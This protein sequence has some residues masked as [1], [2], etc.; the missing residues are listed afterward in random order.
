MPINN[1][2]VFVSAVVTFENNS[3][4]H[5]LQYQQGIEI[6]RRPIGA[7][8]LKLQNNISFDILFLSIAYFFFFFFFFF[9]L[10][11]GSS[12]FAT[13]V[14]VSKMSVLDTASTLLCPTP[15]PV[16]YTWV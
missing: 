3:V 2:S 14:S 8:S 6:K 10:T 13:G 12:D 11:T 9:S 15:F 4:N 7:V 1:T 16:L 5:H